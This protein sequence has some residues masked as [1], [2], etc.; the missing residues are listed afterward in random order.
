LHFNYK[1]IK[2]SDIFNWAGFRLLL[3]R[4]GSISAV[5]LAAGRGIALA[6]FYINSINKDVKNA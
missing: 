1:A 6:A 2:N 5:L 3:E 4:F